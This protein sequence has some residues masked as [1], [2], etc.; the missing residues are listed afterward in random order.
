MGSEKFTA[1]QRIAMQMQQDLI[2]MIIRTNITYQEAQQAIQTGLGFLL[3]RNVAPRQAQEIIITLTALAKNLGFEGARAAQQVRSAF[4]GTR[5]VLLNM[6]QSLGLTRKELS[7]LSGDEFTAKMQ[8]RLQFLRETVLQS[9]TL[10]KTQFENV[11]DVIKYIL[12]MA[13]EDAQRRA[14][15]S[16]NAIVSYFF[17]SSNKLTAE[18]E[19]VKNA[20][21][22]LFSSISGV[23]EKLAQPNVLSAL[24]GTLTNVLSIVKQIGT[25][26]LSWL[27][28]GDKF[29]KQMSNIE[30]VT[31]AFSRTQQARHIAQGLKKSYPELAQGVNDNE[32]YN[33]TNAI[34][35]RSS[36]LKNITDVDIW[37]AS[38]KALQEYQAEIK[39]S[40]ESFS[41]RMSLSEEAPIVKRNAGAV[42]AELQKINAER[43]KL[44]D[45]PAESIAPRPS[46]ILNEFQARD[47]NNVKKVYQQLINAEVETPQ[48]RQK[49]KEVNE[50]LTKYEALSKLEKDSTA[51]QELKAKVIK[52]QNEYL[53]L[54]KNKEGQIRIDVLGTN[55][56]MEARQKVYDLLQRYAREEDQRATRK[57][58]VTAEIQRLSYVEKQ[59]AA[60]NQLNRA[61][62]GT[63]DAEKL[64][65][66][67]I[68]QQAQE[69]I[70]SARLA[71]QE[72]IAETQRASARARLMQTPDDKQQAQVDFAKA[73]RTQEERR[74]DV[75]KAII[76]QYQQQN[77]TMSDGGRFI[78]ELSEKVRTQRDLLQQRNLEAM[79]ITGA[80]LK[81]IQFQTTLS[82]EN[83]ELQR[84][85]NKIEQF[86]SKLQSA[87]NVAQQQFSVLNGKPSSGTED[88]RVYLN[89]LLSSAQQLRATVNA[90]PDA[91]K[92]NPKVSTIF[93]SWTS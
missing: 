77:K 30:S 24:V 35:R 91:I 75:I 72:A 7:T 5:S 60:T 63:A 57:L 66:L 78:E 51:G 6:L 28:F 31:A 8:N 32:I 39:T 42:V 61:I 49:G 27:G 67:V 20:F 40:G 85:I 45:K 58:A 2:G 17:D 38:K 73:I 84:T 65:E 14:G 3:A 50:F 56:A 43:Q 29:E 12:G 13:F 10:L 34:I 59:I 81:D 33:L 21:G 4:T 79:G 22:E 1:S 71:Y 36:N 54:T 53:E 16:L 64:E 86:Q 88:V 87:A 62:L 74:L 41:Q 80:V 11:G 82:R 92:V 93:V 26:M 55:T 69:R 23:L 89:D 19:R 90:N 68:R 25:G 37:N 76:D 52:A 15:R 18:G 48:M 9:S 47:V 46:I 44:A 70:D 83:E